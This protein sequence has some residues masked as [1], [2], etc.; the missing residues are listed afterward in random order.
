MSRVLACRFEYLAAAHSAYSGN[1]GIAGISLQRQAARLD[2]Y[3]EELEGK[4]AHLGRN[5]PLA[6]LKPSVA[7]DSLYLFPHVG[8]WGFSPEPKVWHDFL[9]WFNKLDDVDAAENWVTPARTG[10]HVAPEHDSLPTRWYRQ[11]LS[12][13][14]GEL[15]LSHNGM[16]GATSSMW[17]AHFDKFCLQRGLLVLHPHLYGDS[18][19][20]KGLA[21]SWRV[22]GAHYR[23][24]NSPDSELLSLEAWR[25]IVLSDKIDLFPQSNELAR[26]SIDGAQILKSTLKYPERDQ[27]QLPLN[28]ATRRLFA[29]DVYWDLDNSLALHELTRAVNGDTFGFY[30][31]LVTVTQ[32]QAQCILGGRSIVILGDSISRYFTYQFNN[33]LIRGDIAAEWG[34]E[35]D[36][37]YKWGCGTM[38]DGED[39]YVGPYYDCGKTWS[40]GT[41]RSDRRD[42]RQFITSTIPGG[43]YA[44]IE[45]TFYFIQDTWY[46]ALRDEASAIRDHDVIIIN[47]GWWELK[48]DDEEDHKSDSCSFDKDDASDFYTDAD[49]LESFEDDLNA[50]VEDILKWFVV[51]ADKAVVWREITCCGVSFS[52]VNKQRL[53]AI[54]VGAMNAIADKVMADSS[55]DIVPVYQLSNVVN[56]GKR[57]FDGYHPRS[58]QMHIWTQLC[59]NKIAKQLSRVDECLASP[60]LGPSICPSANPTPKATTA[61]PSLAPTARPSTL[62]VPDP[63]LAPKPTSMPSSAAP[64]PKTCM[65]GERDGTETD[66][67]CGGDACSS[68]DFGF[69]CEASSDCQQGVC[70]NKLCDPNPSAVP[71]QL[72]AAAPVSVPTLHPATSAPSARKPISLLPSTGHPFLANTPRPTRDPH[73]WPT[74]QPT[75]DPG[76]SS[77]S[78]TG[79]DVGNNVR[80]AASSQTLIVGNKTIEFTCFS[81][82][83]GITYAGKPPFGSMQCPT[84]GQKI[85]LAILMA[86]FVS[87]AIAL[88]LRPPGKTRSNYRT[89]QTAGQANGQSL[90]GTDVSTLEDELSTSALQVLRQMEDIEVRS[91]PNQLA[92]VAECKGEL[93]GFG[94]KSR[95]ACPAKATAH[96][97]VR[98][99]SSTHRSG[100][101]VTSLRDG[102]SYAPR[103]SISLVNKTLSISG[104]SMRT[105]SYAEPHLDTKVSSVAF[106]FYD[107]GDSDEEEED[108]AAA[109]DARTGRTNGERTCETARAALEF[110]F[111]LCICTVG[112]HRMPSGFLPA[113]TTLAPENPDLWF[114]IMVLIFLVSL[115]NIEVLD[116]GTEVFLSRA[117]ANEWKGWMQV[118]FVAYHYTNNNDVYVPIR[119]CVSAYVWLTGFG[120]G[121]YFWSSA[122]FSFK[123]FAQ[124]L[125]RMNFLCLFLS[126]STGT[127]WIE[128][129]FVALATVH[130]ILIWVSL[131]IAR[132]F[133]HFVAGW[134][135]PEKKEHREACYAEKA[136]GCAI[137]IGLCCLIWLDPHNDGE[138]VYDVFFR[139]CLINISEYF[140]WYFWMRTKM[141][142]L[143]S[144]PGL[145]FAAVYTP[146]RDAWPFGISR[147]ARWG[148]G[149]I[150]LSLLVVAIWVSQLP[151][152][153][154]NGGADYRAVNPYIGTLWIPSY[155]LLRNAF[156]WLSR[157]IMKPIEW[158]GMHS[159]EFYLLQFHIFLTSASHRI[160]YLIPKE[161]WGYTNMCLVGCVYFV[162]VIKA[163]EVT[164]V[165]RNIAWRTSRGKVIVSILWT[166]AAYATLADANWDRRSCSRVP[167]MLWIM[168][169]IIAT[170][171]FAYWTMIS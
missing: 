20:E 59:L 72:P 127:P 114:F 106:S 76:S 162:V 38:A 118:A 112:E 163:L 47:S 14:R 8:S 93:D 133:G 152:Y 56:L 161:D 73:P 154:C 79:Y 132:V 3:P 110:A 83:D 109:M 160:L 36:G 81:S 32:E 141:D 9:N 51:D 64:T 111:L 156:P 28:A 70:N 101:R 74:K 123:R 24:I 62:P 68:C 138:G 103:T 144:I 25:A 11:A 6:E 85:L 89:F 117:Q 17:T 77:G 46:S 80:E 170:G 88:I 143:S 142:Y 10:K 52:E 94:S 119:W 84:A 86:S 166:I 92:S 1:Q 63:T 164:N 58:N 30:D 27:P 131:G 99:R 15:G 104:A 137:M 35:G 13:Q 167:R 107:G 151:Q 33:F 139:P 95:Q 37:C 130:F 97:T 91:G 22:D 100:S 50:L 75:Q 21:R 165:L 128:Y 4:R 121:V 44:D 7:R 60:S 41:Y 96:L 157:R 19:T 168:W 18:S 48:K 124:Q 158:I 66:V 26:L 31:P 153:C 71:T 120:N 16:S 129:Y 145:C 61:Q 55:I 105:S 140:E 54:A 43:R 90:D 42:H 65:N 113:G 150:S 134:D 87:Y 78:S 23:G 126:L 98:H 2:A 108:N 45:T 155:L 169:C 5:Q 122:D 53:G 135:Q 136:L 147:L 171:L 115:L 12:V 40:D 69:K 159:L 49:C 116:E 57:T 102:S 39:C 82:N 148:I 67:D 34:D 125:W 149:L 146:F 29:L